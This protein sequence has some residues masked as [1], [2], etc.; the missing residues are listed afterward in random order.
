L[1][2]ARFLHGETALSDGT[3]NVTWLR[4]DRREMQG[5]DWTNGHSRSVGLM[6]AQKGTA[7]LL[8][9]LNAYHEDLE[10]RTP[11]PTPVLEWRLLADSARGLIEP[12]EPA[13]GHGAV[14][15]LPARSVLL[16]EGLLQ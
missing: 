2:Q 1:R 16:F 8:L 7:P 11:R 15:T 10:Y 12:N 6:L 5:E 9:L 14:V 4:P 13:I 3:K